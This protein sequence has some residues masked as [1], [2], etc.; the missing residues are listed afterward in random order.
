MHKYSFD[1]KYA[2]MCDCAVAQQFLTICICQIWVKTS[3]ILQVA[4]SL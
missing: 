2:E 1:N 4:D 3:N